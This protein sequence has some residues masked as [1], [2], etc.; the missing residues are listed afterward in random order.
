M[1]AVKIKLEGGALLFALVISLL[2]L[3]SVSAMISVNYYYGLRYQYSTELARLQQNMESATLLALSG[4]LQQAHVATDSAVVDLFGSGRDTVHMATW[5][6]GLLDGFDISGQYKKVSMRRRALTGMEMG[7]NAIFYV[8]DH[9]REIAMAGAVELSGKV[10][11]PKAGYRSATL[12]GTSL[13]G[14]PVA[15]KPLVS[16]RFLPPLN[17]SI[18]EKTEKIF[19]SFPAASTDAALFLQTD[20]ISHSFSSPPLCIV[21]RGDHVLSEKIISGNIIIC[22]TGRITI[23]KSC[24]ITDAIL[25][26]RYVLFGK[27][28]EFS[29]QVFATDTILSEEKCMFHYPSIL[30][31]AQKK[32]RAAALKL[33]KENS[34]TGS[35]VGIPHKET[36]NIPFTMQAGELSA[37][38]GQVHFN[39]PAA[40]AGTLNGEFYFDHV[41]V[42]TSSSVNDNFI[43]NLKVN[44][45]RSDPLLCLLPLLEKDAASPKKNILKWTR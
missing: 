8:A 2:V 14:D 27:E 4:P 21:L 19:S 39:G 40:L 18:V 30:V 34:F 11:L 44:K 29:G 38:T 33:G 43:Y 41:F 5:N 31:L 15:G 26:A 17:K 35:I 10:F 37:L 1:S 23:K 45:E 13:F 3:L 28:T 9:D 36:I 20:S 32:N 42:R 12:S 7:D 22:C 6:Y 24:R 16:E 25:V